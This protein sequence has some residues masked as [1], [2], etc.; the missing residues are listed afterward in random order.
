MYSSLMHAKV[1]AAQKRNATVLGTKQRI[2][3]AKNERYGQSTAACT[4]MTM[5]L[6]LRCDVI[7]AE[8][9]YREKKRKGDVAKREVL[10]VLHPMSCVATPMIQLYRWYKALPAK[11]MLQVGMAH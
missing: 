11:L 9:T 8:I 7:I 6:D 4:Q 5:P 2:A 3:R 10:T 1:Q